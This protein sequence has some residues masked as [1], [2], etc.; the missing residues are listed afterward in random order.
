MLLPLVQRNPMNLVWKL[1]FLINNVWNDGSLTSLVNLHVEKSICNKQQ[2]N[3]Y[4]NINRMTS[5]DIYIQSW[6]MLWFKQIN[7]GDIMNSW[8][9][10]KIKVKS[11]HRHLLDQC[12]IRCHNK[13]IWPYCMLC[14]EISICPNATTLCH[15]L[16]KKLW[17]IMLMHELF[18]ILSDLLMN[19]DD[20]GLKEL[21]MVKNVYALSY[22]FW[23]CDVAK[24]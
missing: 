9:Y 3:I 15:Q 6:L 10:L 1:A 2:L 11:I 22:S 7:I 13:W 18:L 16:K 4:N 14:L 5:Q 20:F 19:L 8:V 17:Y 24:K 21:Q 23:V 12:F